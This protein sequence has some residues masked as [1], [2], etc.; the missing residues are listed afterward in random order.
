MDESLYWPIKI[1]QGIDRSFHLIIYPFMIRIT[2][3]KGFF[4]RGEIAWETEFS[5]Q[6]WF[7]MEASTGSL[8]D[9]WEFVI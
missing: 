1:Q 2:L 6:L 8:S 4:L 5:R 3:K 9:T 7:R